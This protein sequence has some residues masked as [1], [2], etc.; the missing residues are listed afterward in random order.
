MSEIQDPVVQSQEDMEADAL[1]E[2]L[3]QKYR[4]SSIIIGIVGLFVFGIAAGVVA[5]IMARKAE[6][7]GVAA[8]AGKVLAAF[9]LIS[10]IIAY[11]VFVS[12]T[13]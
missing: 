8:T 4:R 2:G 11:T 10:G 9:D 12:L 3:G 7:H 1:R 5:F 6:A 13:K